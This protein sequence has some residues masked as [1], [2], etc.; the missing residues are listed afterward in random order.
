MSSETLNLKC[1][2]ADGTALRGE[3]KVT[4]EDYCEAKCPPGKEAYPNKMSTCKADSKWTNKINCLGV[5]IPTDVLKQGKLHL[6]DGYGSEVKDLVD[7]EL[8]CTRDDGELVNPEKLLEGTKCSWNDGLCGFDDEGFAYFQTQPDVTCDKDGSWSS[9]EN[10]EKETV[11]EPICRSQPCSFV[12]K[13]AISQ[14]DD[15]VCKFESPLLSAIQQNIAPPSASPKTNLKQNI[16]D[17]MYNEGVSCTLNSCLGDYVPLEPSTM[18]CKAGSWQP[19]Q[20]SCIPTSTPC[21]LSDLAD[22]SNGEVDC[23]EA[24]KVIM[25][26]EKV[27]GGQTCPVSCNSGYIPSKQTVQ[28]VDGTWT[29]I[30]CGKMP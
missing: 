10:Q 14:A 18:T 30:E 1:Y 24:E 12:D 16:D 27:M 9:Y 7:V 8:Q 17:D 3:D 19:G 4:F 20:L 11:T 22:P 23:S 13:S 15:L 2:K 5:C 26:E 28:C 29:D 25:S 21:H 6:E